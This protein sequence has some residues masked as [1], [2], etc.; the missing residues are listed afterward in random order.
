MA[1]W[2][3]WCRFG[4][5][6]VPVFPRVRQLLAEGLIG[7]VRG[8]VYRWHNPRLTSIPFTWRDDAEQS[9][10]GSVA[11]GGSHAYDTMRWLTGLEA[12]RVFAHRPACWRRRSPT[13]A[14]PTSRRRSA[15]SEAHDATGRG[16]TAEGHGVR[17]RQPHVRDGQRRRWRAHGFARAVSADGAGAGRRTARR[18]GFPWP[19]TAGPATYASRANPANRSTSRPCRRPTIINNFRDMVLSRPAGDDGRRAHRSAGVARRLAGANLYGRCGSVRR[20]WDLGGDGRVRRPVRGLAR[21]PRPGG[22]C[23]PSPW[24]LARLPRCRVRRAR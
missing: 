19:S 2:D 21:S 8:I 18:R 10:A 9:A 16:I 20:A 13:W 1:G 15:W 17:L 12:R 5:R 22:P 4:S 7:E 23:G 11:D 14:S 6:G 3:I 24:R